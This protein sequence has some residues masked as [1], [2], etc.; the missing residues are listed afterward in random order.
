MEEQLRDL[1]NEAKILISAAQRYMPKGTNPLD[2]WAYDAADF[3]D[4]AQR[5][6]RL[7]DANH[8]AVA[9]RNGPHA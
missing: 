2:N 9:G 4:R 8:L 6:E 3:I 7:H 1:L 5:M